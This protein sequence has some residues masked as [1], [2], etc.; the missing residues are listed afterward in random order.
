M[1]HHKTLL[2]LITTLALAAC[3][4]DTKK[5]PSDIPTIPEGYGDNNDPAITQVIEGTWSQACT[6][7][8]G[9]IAKRQQV[10][11]GKKDITFVALEYGDSGCTNLHTRDT[12]IGQYQLGA[13]SKIVNDE[14]FTFEVIY[15][16]A[17]SSVHNE[18]FETT[19]NK[20]KTC[21]VTDWKIG[22]AVDVSNWEKCAPLFNPR[23]RKQLRFVR[24]E[25]DRATQQPVLFLDDQLK[26]T[27][28][29]ID[30]TPFFKGSL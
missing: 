20:A 15:T 6:S 27:G 12:Y 23:A 10:T 17:L 25:V 5:T 11:F 1:Y 7:V 3:G 26:P 14:V 24:N 18:S 9:N 13:K 21:S 2:T 19:R 29:A 4:S 28:T 22:V 30:L 16:Q 8:S